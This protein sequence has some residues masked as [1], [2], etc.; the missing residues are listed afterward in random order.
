MGTTILLSSLSVT[1]AIIVLRIFFKRRKRKI[2]AIYLCKLTKNGTFKEIFTSLSK[3]FSR[4]LDSFCLANSHSEIKK[5]LEE[6]KKWLCK[7]NLNTFVLFRDKEKFFVL[8]TGINSNDTIKEF[9][10]ELKDESLWYA[11]YNFCMAVP[12]FSKK[13]A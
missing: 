6:K 7:K 10:F 3:H 4:D 11:E 2:V 1:A 5:I 9:V 13:I 8:C 12:E